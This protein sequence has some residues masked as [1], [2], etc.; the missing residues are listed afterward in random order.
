MA[1]RWGEREEEE[2]RGFT[3]ALS[4]LGSQEHIAIWWWGNKK[5]KSEEGIKCCTTE[6][7]SWWGST[8]KGFRIIWAGLEISKDGNIRKSE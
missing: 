1:E 3:M 7:N 5:I 2:E 8:C 6:K 4:F